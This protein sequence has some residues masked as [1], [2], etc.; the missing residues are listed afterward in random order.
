MR[1]QKSVRATMR[2]IWKRFAL[3]V[4]LLAT[5][6]SAAVAQMGKGPV[7]VDE[8]GVAVKGY[9][10]VSFHTA[11]SATQGSSEFKAM[12]DGVTYHFATVANRDLFVSDPARYAPAYGGYCAMGVAVGQKFDID[13]AAFR[14]VDGKLFLNKDAATQRV[15]LRDVP[16]NLKKADSRWPEVLKLSGFGR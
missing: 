15:W 3:V 4:G 12:H 13:P 14:V 10:V 2:A 7:N 8:S 6:A 11:M 9:D 5:V 16:G 1:D